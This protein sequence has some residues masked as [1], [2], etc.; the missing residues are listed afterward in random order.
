VLA[1]LF[2]AIGRG[3]VPQSPFRTASWRDGKEPMT[4]ITQLE[5][6]LLSNDGWPDESQQVR[7]PCISPSKFAVFLF[8]EDIENSIDSIESN[9]LRSGKRD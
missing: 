7:G 2:D 6:G 5:P 9:A 1:P 8:V 3:R 4:A